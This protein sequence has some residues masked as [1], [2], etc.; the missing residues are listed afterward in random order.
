MPAISAV[1]PSES[2][3]VPVSCISPPVLG[4][5][6]PYTSSLTKRPEGM[7]S[8]KVAMS[9]WPSAMNVASISSRVMRFSPVSAVTLASSA[10]NSVPS[11][12][13]SDNPESDSSVAHW[14]SHVTLVSLP[15]KTLP[16]V[17]SELGRAVHL[18]VSSAY[19]LGGS[20][21]IENERPRHRSKNMLTALVAIVFRDCFVTFSLGSA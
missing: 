21:A 16:L 13:V 9:V 10:L 6:T 3:N 7:S 18:I 1:V 14:P 15:P 20:T 8:V 19:E 4:K 2:E 17:S 12:N 5:K 11:G